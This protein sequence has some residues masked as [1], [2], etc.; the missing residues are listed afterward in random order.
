MSGKVK[1]RRR[2]SGSRRASDGKGD[3]R[4]IA[5]LRFRT[6]GL[7]PGDESNR[8]LDRIDQ[9]WVENE[10]FC[11]RVGRETDWTEIALWTADAL[12]HGKVQI[13]LPTIDHVLAEQLRGCAEKRVHAP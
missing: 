13:P 11:I 1:V 7:A 3:R 10:S 9:L 4:M 8:R 12:R 6:P 5:G 2:K